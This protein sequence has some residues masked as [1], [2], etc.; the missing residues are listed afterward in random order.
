MRLESL[1]EG[2]LDAFSYSWFADSL[3]S[4]LPL[5]ERFG[6]ATPDEVGIDTLAGRLRADTVAADAI[7]K[8][9]DLVSAWTRAS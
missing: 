2:G 4:M 6:V 5:V 8:A 1:V 9:P 7:V 3:R